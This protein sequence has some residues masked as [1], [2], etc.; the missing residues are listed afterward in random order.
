MHPREQTGGP[1]VADGALASRKCGSIPHASVERIS[2]RAIIL[3]HVGGG[4]SVERVE[5]RRLWDSLFG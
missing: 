1:G 2:K 5:N 3:D 4:V